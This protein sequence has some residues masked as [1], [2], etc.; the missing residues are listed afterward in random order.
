MTEFVLAKKTD[1]VVIAQLRKQIW[2]TTYRGIYPDTMIDDFDFDWH[3]QKDQV[4]ICNS[5]YLVYM[6][7]EEDTPVGYLTL[8][9][10][11]PLFLMSLYVL[12]EYQHCGIGTKAFHQIRSMCKE[13]GIETFTCQ[14]QPQ[15]G[16]AMAFYRAMGSVITARDEENEEVWQNSVTFTFAV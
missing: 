14:C 11:D 3:T 7:M 6:I 13:Q 9:K 4:R 15:N 1:A 2:N 16:Q 12:A 5:A 8:K 10:G